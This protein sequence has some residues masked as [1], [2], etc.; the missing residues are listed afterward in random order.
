ML[1]FTKIYT[2]EIYDC[3]GEVIH[4]VNIEGTYPDA[5]IEAEELTDILL[6]TSYTIRQR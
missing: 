3:I 1:V 5:D 4:K 2:I 6:G